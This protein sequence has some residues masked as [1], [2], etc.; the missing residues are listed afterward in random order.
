MTGLQPNVQKLQDYNYELPRERIAQH[1]VASRS[2]ARMMVVHRV[3]GKFE[4]C[5]V[6]DFPQ[7]LQAGDSVVVNDSKVMPAR[8]VGFRTQ[9]KGRWEGLF[10]QQDEASGIGELLCKT[11]GKMELGETV[12]LRD[13]DGRE[14]QKLVLLSQQENGRAMFHAE[15]AITWPELLQVSGRVP[16]P[17]YIRDGEMMADDLA[18]YQTV[19]ARRPGSV[20]APTAGLHF[21]PELINQVRGAGA[22][23]VTTTLHVGVGTFRPIQ[24]EDLSQH[25]MHAE[26]CDVSEPVAKRLTQTQTEG[27]RVIA[28]GTTS[29]RCLESAAAHNDGQIK[30]WQGQTDLFITPGFEFKA[31]DA[32]L[33]NFHLPKS[34]LLVMVSAFANRELIMDAYQE[35]IKQ[36]YR[37]YSYGDCMLIL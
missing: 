30:A 16:L 31:V 20:A 7:Y 15:P 2:A 14:V 4:H 23:F 5:Q 11:R 3:S 26:W 17:P 21:T 28:V 9:T 1:P 24:T 10:L 8:L 33:T 29:V 6:R 37:F 36:E 18:R 13:T 35:A 22:S 34:S 27:G 32:L 19:Y 25:Q 12:T